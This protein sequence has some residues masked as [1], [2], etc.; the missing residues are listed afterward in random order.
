MFSLN[1]SD[2]VQQL[3]NIFCPIEKWD[4]IRQKCLDDRESSINSPEPEWQSWRESPRR[5][6]WTADRLRHCI[7]AKLVR[8]ALV[9]WPFG[10]LFGYQ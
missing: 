9:L 2:N 5:V 7:V 3:L 6:V 4:L 8:K 1:P 10:R